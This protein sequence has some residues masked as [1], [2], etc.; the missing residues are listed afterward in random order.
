MEGRWQG[1]AG[2]TVRLTCRPAGDSKLPGNA[3]RSDT[4]V[5]SAYQLQPLK[6]LPGSPNSLPDC[7]LRR[8][9]VPI[10]KMSSGYATGTGLVSFAGPLPWRGKKTTQ[11]GGKSFRRYQ[12]LAAFRKIVVVRRFKCPESLIATKVYP[13]CRVWLSPVFASSLFNFCRGLPMK[14]SGCSSK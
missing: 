10:S 14:T 12:R 7:D 6:T 9:G 2:I 1:R 4:H 5:K 8:E 11:C 3:L 13:D